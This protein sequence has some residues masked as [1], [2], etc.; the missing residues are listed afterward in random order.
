MKNLKKVLIGI[1][2]RRHTPGALGPGNGLL[3]KYLNSNLPISL[4][5]KGIYLTIF[6][7]WIILMFMNNHHIISSFYFAYFTYPPC[8]VACDMRR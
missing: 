8:V 3:I 4:N 7:A 6:Y 1:P 5:L 2:S